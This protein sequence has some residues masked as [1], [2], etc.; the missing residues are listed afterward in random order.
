MAEK[1]KEVVDNGFK[2]L[3]A[4]LVKN[5]VSKSDALKKIQ[6]QED[7]PRHKAIIELTQIA[8]GL[9]PADSDIKL[10]LT[11][12]EKRAHQH[13]RSRELISYK[14]FTF[15]LRNVTNFD[16]PFVE[17]QDGDVDLADN[18]VFKNNTRTIGKHKIC[19]R[20]FL[21]LSNKFGKTYELVD[22]KKARKEKGLTAKARTEA[23]T[24]IEQMSDTQL[25]A[26]MLYCTKYKWSEIAG[27]D[28]DEMN[29]ELVEFAFAQPQ[30][31]LSLK[32]NPKVEY[33]ATYNMGIHANVITFDKKNG[34]IKWRNGRPVCTVLSDEDP[35]VKFSIYVHDNS[36]GKGM[37]AYNNLKEKLG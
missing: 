7:D 22:E 6:E 16:T 3:L 11:E 24:Y 17:L 8:D 33:Q 28:E 35:A 25:R 2:E 1:E 20:R 13:V 27:M 26:A 5:D 19:E 31:L 15:E 37:E 32:E 36:G 10:K 21:L 18:I 30:E 29:G 12:K 34:V 9:A 14:G 4:Q 23:I